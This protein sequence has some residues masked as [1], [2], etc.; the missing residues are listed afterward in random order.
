MAFAA[1]CY[2]SPNFH[3]FFGF[4]LVWKLV[5]GCSGLSS[6]PPSLHFY[7]LLLPFFVLYFSHLFIFYFAF[8]SE[9]PGA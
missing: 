2:F 4:H 1:V 3:H 6:S 5:D 7:F 8:G 9:S